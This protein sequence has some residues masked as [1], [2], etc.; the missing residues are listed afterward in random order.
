M[1]LMMKDQN[2]DNAIKNKIK[3]KGKSKEHQL[4]PLYVTCLF[5]IG[6]ACS[7]VTPI[8]NPIPEFVRSLKESREKLFSIT[9]NFSKFKMVRLLPNG[10]QT[11]A[12]AKPFSL[13]KLRCDTRTWPEKYFTATGLWITSCDDFADEDILY[14]TP[15]G[16]NEHFFWPQKKMGDI[17]EVPNI[18]TPTNEPIK[19]QVLT[20]FPR[21]FF[22]ENFLS[23]QEMKVLIKRATDPSNPHKLQKSTVGP[24]HWKEGTRKN[25]ATDRTSNNAFDIQSETARRVKRRS[26]ELLR[27]PYK[28]PLADGLQIL[29]YQH[30]QGY[31]VHTDFFAIGTPV[32]SGTHNFD[33]QT[34]GSNRFATVFLYLS[35]V[36]EGAG[37]QTMFPK[38]DTSKI[39]SY[40]EMKQKP[41]VDLANKG[42]E[43]WEN[44]LAELCYSGVLSVRPKKGS[45]LLFYNQLPNGKLDE[46]SLH[47]GCPVLKGEKWAS[48]MWVWN[49]CRYT[50]ACP[51][52]PEIYHKG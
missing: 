1:T 26:F 49:D 40:N 13:T 4:N 17:F 35:D 51:S 33:P 15:K 8:V 46:R 37:G 16:R 7:C 28:E 44:S 10:A 9:S 31:N 6:L 29:R 2:E 42:Q 52:E 25:F 21:T 19:L 48:N 41:E 23:D 22:V 30:T 36:E 5:F 47:S 34:G 27:I 32:A 50:V 24:E 38:A 11:E 12:H 3:N 14:T 43:G 39:E 45:A 18:D 20:E